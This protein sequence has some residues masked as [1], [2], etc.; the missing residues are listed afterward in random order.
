MEQCIQNATICVRKEGIIYIVIHIYTYI[1]LTLIQGL[2]VN[3]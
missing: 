1:Y 2:Y 3:L